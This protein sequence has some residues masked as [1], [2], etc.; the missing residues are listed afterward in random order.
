[1]FLLAPCRRFK[2]LATRPLRIYEMGPKMSDF[3]PKNELD[4]AIVAVQRSPWM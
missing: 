4:R 1:M 2:S 3:I